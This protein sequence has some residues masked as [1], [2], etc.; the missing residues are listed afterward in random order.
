MAAKR[1]SSYAEIDRDLEILQLERD[2]HL[3]KMKLGL[4]KAK[5]N[6]KIGNVVE[7][8]FEFSKKGTPSVVTQILKFALPFVLKFLKKKL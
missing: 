5:E 8:Y 6:L 7:G 4:D 3:E 1:Y 2:I